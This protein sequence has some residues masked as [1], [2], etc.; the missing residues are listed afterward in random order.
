[1]KYCHP[2][3]MQ[4]KKE[5]AELAKEET[6]VADER[7]KKLEKTVIIVYEQNSDVFVSHNV[8]LTMINCKLCNAITPTSSLQ[9]CYVCG[10]EPKPMNS[11]DE[12]VVRDVDVTNHRFELSALHA[13][14]RDFKCLLHL[15]YRLEIKI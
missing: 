11:V 8:L 15:S 2:I 4:F 3:R 10:A 14:I 6:Y 12:I 9:I 13:W 1:M 5:T 7:I